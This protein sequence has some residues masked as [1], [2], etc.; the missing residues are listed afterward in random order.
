VYSWLVPRVV[1]PLYDRVSR[2]EVWGEV[3]RLRALQWRS[4]DELE[5]RAVGKL[6]DLLGHAVAQVPYY[7]ERFAEAGLESREIESLGDLAG[8]PITTKA[9]LRAGFPTRVVAQNLPASQRRLMTTGGSSCVPLEFFG[10]RAGEDV[11]LATYFFFLDWVGTGIWD[12]TVLVDSL[13]RVSTNIPSPPWHLRRIRRLL[14][15]ERTIYLQAMDLSAA[16]YQAGTRA[17]SDGRPFFIRTLPSY[18]ARLATQLLKAGIRPPR[19]K[20]LISHGETLTAT[21]VAVIEQAF[22]CSV[23]NQYS[24]W[25]VPQMAQ[26]CPD[27]PGLLHVN[28][29]RAVVRVVRDDGGDAVPGEAGRILVTDLANRVMPLINYDIGDR[30]VAGPVCPCG[31]GFPTLSSLEGRIVE[32]IRTPNG[33]VL[34]P[35]I[36]SHLLVSGSGAT[37]YLSEY[38]AVQTADDAVVL[39]VVPTARFDQQFAQ[40]LQ[41]DFEGYLGPSVGV[42]IE[43]VDRIPWE[44]NGKRRIIKSELRNQALEAE[45]G[46]LGLDS[47]AATLTTGMTG[48]GCSR[49]SLLTRATVPEHDGEAVE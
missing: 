46:P 33:R 36:L 48:E 4:P 18:A 19:P 26:S 6:R 11:W 24:S 20:A 7:R 15:G 49:S 8:L 29:E 40:K 37:P 1:L 32:T 31:R 12:T 23:V 13:R 2:R 27:V 21:D 47:C 3:Q 42:S 43:T 35:G 39:R 25:D 41:R 45:A 44:S 16:E 22:G 34:S 5:A 28:S 10:D 30:A 9:D 17:L 38:Q 14:L